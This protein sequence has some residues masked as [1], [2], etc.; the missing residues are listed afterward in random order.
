M[1]K[2]KFR[3]NA[4]VEHSSESMNT[5]SDTK[6]SGDG[7]DGEGSGSDSTEAAELNELK[8]IMF[9]SLRTIPFSLAEDF[10]LRNLN[11]VKCS[12]I[13]SYLNDLD[14]G[15]KTVKAVKY[16]AEEL[17]KFL[18]LNQN[19]S[20]GNSKENNSDKLDRDTNVDDSGDEKEMY[21]D[22]NDPSPD[23]YTDN[24]EDFSED[25]FDDDK[26]EQFTRQ[27]FKKSIDLINEI[28]LRLAR[29][30]ERADLQKEINQ[31]LTKE[32][33]EVHSKVDMAHEKVDALPGAIRSI[34]ENV[35]KD[36]PALSPASN[37]FTIVTP[38]ET[39]I[40]K[41]VFPKQWK[42]IL[43]LGSM[44]KLIM[45]VGETGCGK[46]WLA[47]RL[48]EALDLKFY[49]MSCSEGMSESEG[50]G[51]LLPVGESG[52]FMYIPAGFIT[53]YEKGGVMNA[54]E[55]DNIDPNVGVWF[56]KALSSANFYL[57][58][59]YENPIVT[60]HKDFVWIAC[61]NT[62]GT[63]ASSLYSGRNAL[64]GATLDRHL[65]GTVTLDYDPTVENKIVDP[66]I[67]LWGRTMREAMQK[68]AVDQKPC[69]TRFL[70]DA[71]DMYIAYPD[72]WDLGKI[73]DKFFTNWAEDDV[74]R[75]K[76][77]IRRSVFRKPDVDRRPPKQSFL[78][79]LV[80]RSRY[81]DQT[82]NPGCIVPGFLRVGG[83]G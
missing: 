39:R 45:L 78:C 57:P 8:Q 3:F 70:K 54:D 82:E 74:K 11:R 28:L 44:R 27:S 16:V 79:G 6:K 13:G 56:N 76:V 52:K 65:L 73:Q 60:R 18:K 2:K 47:E 67:L 66:N 53:A 23:S 30:E 10:L 62:Y 55:W 48:A 31:K 17:A 63:G 38:K 20:S 34:V 35:M 21:S 26:L 4:N 49:S 25:D 71:T 43:E 51:W 58:L 72:I 77:V 81:P 59:R 41:G 1:A 22:G 15:L 83:Y 37:E 14:K 42:E 69:S 12:T 50:K 36:V 64:D 9:E 29:L 32:V 46:T 68:L 33:T 80:E 75:T 40:I 61:C 7:T 19:P 24:F 5:S